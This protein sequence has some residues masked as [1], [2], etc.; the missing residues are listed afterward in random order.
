MCGPESRLSIRP[1][2]AVISSRS[3]CKPEAGRKKNGKIPQVRYLIFNLL[4]W[5]SELKWDKNFINVFNMNY[6]WLFK[7]NLIGWMQI[8]VIPAPGVAVSPLRGSVESLERGGVG[9]VFP[10]G[11]WWLSH[12][13]GSSG[14]V[15]FCKRQQKQISQKECK[16]S[17]H[18]YH[19]KF[20]C[21][22]LRRCCCVFALVVWGTSRV[23]FSWLSC[24]MD[25]FSKALPSSC[26]TFPIISGSLLSSSTCRR[27]IRVGMLE[28]HNKG[29][30]SFLNH[31]KG[32]IIEI[33]TSH[34]LQKT[35]KLK[36][37]VQTQSTTCFLTCE[38]FNISSRFVFKSGTSG[39]FGLSCLVCLG[40]EVQREFCFGGLARTQCI[41]SGSL[42]NWL[43]IWLCST[44]ERLD[45]LISKPWLSRPS[46][47]TRRNNKQ[48]NNA[49]E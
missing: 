15:A 5:C 4:T 34:D 19:N 27:M 35:N 30:Q 44:V 22:C 28:T 33:Y 45:L 36:T 46:T 12:D 1:G 8:G 14:N 43:S 32:T 17:K 48:F 40:L 9:L 29:R 42:T 16:I 26:I 38:W 3:D 7:Y 39:L 49:G 24:I 2:L 21:D 41:T 10:L 37:V 47:E 11:P 31:V 6:R 13:V 23:V 20:T 18:H 25:E